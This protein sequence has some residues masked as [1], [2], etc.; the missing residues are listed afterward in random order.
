MRTAWITL[1]ALLL[2]ACGTPTA[3]EPFVSDH[4]PAATAHTQPASAPDQPDQVQTE[5][6]ESEID[7][8]TDEAP[9]SSAPSVPAGVVSNAVFDSIAVGAPC[10]EALDKIGMEPIAKFDVV[11]TVPTGD[12]TLKGMAWPGEGGQSVVITCHP[13]GH[14]TAKDRANP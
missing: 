13:D 4:S 11:V 2:T 9:S 8:H 6:A 7:A 3:T 14:V 12:V 1:A 10:Q 5:T